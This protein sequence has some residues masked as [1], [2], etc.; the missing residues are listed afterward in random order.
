MK[1]FFDID[2]L[3]A[4]AS[5]FP[6]TYPP[7]PLDAIQTGVMRWF[8]G[9]VHEYPPPPSLKGVL[10]P[11]ERVTVDQ[12]IRSF[13]ING[14]TAYYLAGKIG[15]IEVGKF[16]DMIVLNRDITTCNPKLIGQSKVLLT[17]FH[18]KRVFGTVGF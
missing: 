6:V 11:E 3:V 5:D 16:A 12:M 15:S 18:G 13:T 17:L 14:A 7:D 8:P 4:S 1:S 2:V 9:L 10:W